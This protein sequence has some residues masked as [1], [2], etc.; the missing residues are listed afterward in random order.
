MPYKPDQSFQTKVSLRTATGNDA[1]KATYSH[2][3]SNQEIVFTAVDAG[4][5]GNSIT[6]EITDSTPLSVSVTGT[7]ISIVA[8]ATADSVNDVIA[9]VYADTD[10]AA[11]VDV[12][13]G[14]GDG[15]GLITALAQTNL[16]TGADATHTYSEI[17]GVQDFTIPGLGRALLEYTN[18]SSPQAYEQILKSKIKR[19]RSLSIP[20]NLDLSDTVHQALLA[21]EASD[22]NSW[23]QF[24]PI[25]SGTRFSFQCEAAIT[26]IP[27]ESPVDGFYRTTVEVTLTGAPVLL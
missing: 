12:T 16:A 14:S 2:G 8:D 26:N 17:P 27:L 4:A 5:A 15:T 10:A 13:D 6:V 24:E 9:A 19:G 21:E 11:L 22:E 1:V 25:V 18:H 3:S 23:L 7:A 20:I